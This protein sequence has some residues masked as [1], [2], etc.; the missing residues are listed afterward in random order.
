MDTNSKTKVQ[1]E[2]KK[3][4]AKFIHNH[5]QKPSLIQI[6]PPMISSTLFHAY[7]LLLIFDNVLANIMWLSDDKCLTFIYLTSIWLTISFFIP[8]ETE[9][10]HFL[11]FTKILR[12]WLG[13]ISGAFL[14]LSFM[15]YIVSLIAS[16][17]DTEPPT[18]DEIVVL[19]ESV[20]DKLE[21]LRNE[22]NVWK[23][24]KLSFDGVNKGCSGKR[25]FCRLFLFGTIFQIIIMRYISPGTYTRFFIITGLIYNTSSFQATLRLLWRFTAVRNFYYLGIESFKISSFLPKHLKME[26][27]IP[28][29]QGRAITVPLVEVLPKLLRDKKGDDHIHILQLLLNEQKDNF[30]NEDLKI[31]EIEVYENQRRWYQNKNW[32]TKLLPYERQNYCIEIKNTDGTLTMRSCLPPDEL[33]E[34]ELPNNWHWIND[35]WDGTDW[36]YSDSAWREI[37]QYSSLESFTRSRKWKR[38]LFHL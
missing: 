36:I 2:N 38:R 17:R 34:E 30:G 18:L 3:I 33:G 16:L 13:I 14:F 21:V 29:S 28:L 4:K 15:Y 12:L 8:V 31:L 6:T 35:N 5:G 19:L 7:P 1:T 22:L 27:I 25:L 11:P 26:Q 9:A 24:L 23:K 20:L 32:S 10:S 37:G